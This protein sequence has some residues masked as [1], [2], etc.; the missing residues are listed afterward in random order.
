MGYVRDFQ[1]Y[2]T[3]LKQFYSDFV[4]PTQHQN[5]MLLGYSMGGC[6][7]SLYLETYNQDVDAAVL[8]SPMD[9]LALG[10]FPDLARAIIDF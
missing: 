8:C 3:D 5:H 9:E 6:I 7:A 1:D 2:P 4:R 10:F